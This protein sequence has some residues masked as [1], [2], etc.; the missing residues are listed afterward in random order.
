L[1]ARYYAG[2][3]QKRLPDGRPVTVIADDSDELRIGS[4]TSEML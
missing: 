3:M 1:H 2:A 4:G